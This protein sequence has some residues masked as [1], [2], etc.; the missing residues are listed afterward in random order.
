MIGFAVG[1]EFTTRQAIGGNLLAV[2]GIYG[3]E[4]QKVEIEG[5]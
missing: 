1:E 2:P 3:D 5:K 4:K